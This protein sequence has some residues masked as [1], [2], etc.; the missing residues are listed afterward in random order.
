MRLT[1][2]IVILTIA[3]TLTGCTSTPTRPQIADLPSAGNAIV[4][5][6]DPMRGHF[7]VSSWGLLDN[8]DKLLT[9]EEAR[10]W[11][12][13]MAQ[14]SGWQRPM[15]LYV[16]S[17][18]RFRHVHTVI[19]AFR[20]VGFIRLSFAT[21]EETGDRWSERKELPFFIPI[22]EGD[23][24]RSAPLI[25]KGY[26]GG[27]APPGLLEIKVTQRQIVPR[28]DG[29][30]MPASA[31]TSELA[32]RAESGDQAIAIIVSD[33]ARHSMVVSVLDMIQGHSLT[34][35]YIMEPY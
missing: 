29:R 24:K 16:A 8:G 14:T 5:K 21:K 34:N 1:A 13:D 25:L 23:K 15:R 33:T 11:A 17:D 19:D 31:L 22:R 28:V 7:F 4:A 2:A 3:W 9:P 30:D 12:I 35:V 6:H 27:R 20:R 26:E 32:A 10:Q 18:T